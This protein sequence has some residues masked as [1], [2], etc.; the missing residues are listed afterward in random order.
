[1][2]DIEAKPAY[3]GPIPAVGRIVHYYDREEIVSAVHQKRPPEPF[4]AIIARV[5][6]DTEGVVIPDVATLTVFDPEIGGAIVVRECKLGLLP[7]PRVWL[8]PPIPP[9]ARQPAP[10]PAPSDAPG[11]SVPVPGVTPAT[12]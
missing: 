8:W 5:F 11:T 9:A 1:M 6:K 12:V 4:P 2:S 3:A 10:P 7:A